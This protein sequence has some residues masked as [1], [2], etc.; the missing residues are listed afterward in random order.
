MILKQPN[1]FSYG[2]HQF[3]FLVQPG[4]FLLFSFF[5]TT[6][7]RLRRIVGVE[8]EHADHLITTTALH[9]Q[10]VTK[11]LMKHHR[12]VNVMSLKHHSRVFTMSFER[13]YNIHITFQKV[14][15]CLKP[16]LKDSL[17]LKTRTKPL[18]WHSGRA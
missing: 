6:I 17:N 16:S 12:E 9:H 14:L 4:L 2:Y 5:S 18:T 11:F 1:K 3:G 7:C 13:Y 8:G 15:K 10:I